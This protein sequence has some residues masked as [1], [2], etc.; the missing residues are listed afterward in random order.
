MRLHA[1]RVT[2]AGIA[3]RGVHLLMYLWLG[4]RFGAGG[5]TDQVFFLQAPLL[6]V[7]GI[8]ASTAQLVV[9]PA[10]HRAERDGLEPALERRLKLRGLAVVVPVTAAALAA[11]AV[12]S[13]YRDPTIVLLL[14]PAPAFAALAAVDA[15]VLNARGRHVRAALGPAYGG[16]AG[17]LVLA[18]LP[19]AGW[20]LAAVLTAF[21]AGRW[22][23][24][25][26]HAGASD[27]AARRRPLP[28]A[29]LGWATREAV[30]QIAAVALV[31]LNPLVDV[32]F[33]RRL[34]P[35][36]VTLL[37]YGS[38]LW[39][40][41]P[42]LLSGHLT[43]FH[44][45]FSRRASGETATGPSTH[46]SAAGLGLAALVLSLA[47]AAAA[48][49]LVDLLYGFGR[50][51]GGERDRLARV[52]QAYLVGAGPFLAGVVYV[53]ALTAL[54]RSRAVVVAAGV[55]VAANVGLDALFVVY[56]GLTG[57]ALATSATFLLNAL[58]VAAAFVL[59]T[60]GKETPWPGADA[61]RRAGP[62]P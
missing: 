49:A 7:A 20:A 52:L 35:G 50:L 43:I 42:L 18:L 29:L 46:R 58:A 17:A 6:V 15:G 8:L 62:E 16:L 59:T 60:G 57:L 1:L 24:L 31:A 5:I 27:P 44:A 3:A 34:A 19:R 10:I 53:R 12:V 48:P 38:R 11:A 21:E 9:M 4:N 47:I 56:W 51:G 32:L 14:A 54:G 39:Y 2:A 41:V 25:R 28:S 30:L 33:A 36:S 22:A 55:S 45:R 13:G 37:E 61:D 40:V 23:G 26:L